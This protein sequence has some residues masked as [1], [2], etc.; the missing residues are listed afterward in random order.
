MLNSKPSKED[1]LKTLILF[2][3]LASAAA[4]ANVFEKETLGECGIYTFAKHPSGGLGIEKHVTRIPFAFPKTD[5]VVQ[6]SATGSN[7]IR[8]GVGE[9]VI[10]QNIEMM[11]T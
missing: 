1:N 6:N 8:Y 9:V 4:N 5:P 7:I 10:A 2:T 3:L 11:D